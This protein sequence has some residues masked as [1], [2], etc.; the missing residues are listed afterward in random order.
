MGGGLWLT[1]VDGAG[2]MVGTYG[3]WVM[4]CSVVRLN[5][6]GLVNPMIRLCQWEMSWVCGALGGRAWRVLLLLFFITLEP[7]VE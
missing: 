1:V 4:V 6:S 7:K 5:G 3:R 2:F